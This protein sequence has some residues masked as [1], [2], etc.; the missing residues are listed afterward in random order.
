[1]FR[2]Y[3]AVEIRRPDTWGFAR[4]A[5][6]RGKESSGSRGGIASSV[7]GFVPA[8]TARESCRNALRRRRADCFHSA[9]SILRKFLRYW[10]PLLVWMTMIFLA[11]GDAESGPHASRLIEPLLRW[12]FPHLTP[13]AA[14]MALLLVRKAA[15]T[16]EYALLAFLAWRVWRRPVWGDA[17]PWSWSEAGKAL[18]F[19][20]VY[21]ASDEFHQTFVPTR[22]GCWQ[23]VVIDTGG[24]MV[25]LLLL[26]VWVRWRSRAANR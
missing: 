8:V 24:A 17:R 19:S 16:T 25:G 4:G 11:S 22:V 7:G 10:L 20:V 15:H 14:D 13:A 5:G 21:A 18:L 26:W 1:M 6:R 23:D 2:P 3:R 9:V 12:L